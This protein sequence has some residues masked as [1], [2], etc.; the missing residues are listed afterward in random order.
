M[1]FPTHRGWSRTARLLLVPVP[2]SCES[3]V[4]H[5]RLQGSMPLVI[6]PNR[7]LELGASTSR[8]STKGE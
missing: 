3:I 8:W 7:S 5:A 4:F 1:N 2:V 6:Q